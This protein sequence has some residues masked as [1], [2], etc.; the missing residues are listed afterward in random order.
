MASTEPSDS[1]EKGKVVSI[2]YTLRNDAG[3]VLDSSGGRE[4][5]DY[6]HGSGNIVP[7]L[8]QSLLGRRVGAK[9]TVDVSPSLG[10][11]ERDPRGVQRVPRSSFPKDADVKAGE[12]FT[13]SG[14]DGEEMALW[15]TE[16]E[17]DEVTVDFNHPLAG[18]TL[19][20]EVHV[21]GVRAA[22]KDEIA[23][24]HPH[25]PHGHHHHHEH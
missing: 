9:F 16:V 2:H 13:A 10:F 19:H 23:H 25:G 14:P 7:G 6:L 20:F 8:E 4:P 12:R 22:S 15:I 11:G 3:E 21:T 5:L 24:G 1:I 18:E 17:G